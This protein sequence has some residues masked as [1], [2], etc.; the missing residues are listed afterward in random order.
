VAQIQLQRGR[1][2]DALA[3]AREG[4]AVMTSLGIGGQA[5]VL[6]RLAEADALAAMGDESGGH[7]ALQAARDAVLRGADLIPDADARQTFLFRVP[8]NR[9]LVG[10]AESEFRSGT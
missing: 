9:R 8:E 4:I 5:E 3:S 6:L 10:S 7:A 2:V 1:I